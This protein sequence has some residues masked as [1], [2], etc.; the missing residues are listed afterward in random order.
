MRRLLAPLLLALSILVVTPAAAFAVDY[1]VAVGGDDAAGT[2]APD[3]PFASV[4]KAIDVAA[5]GGGNV[6]VGPGTFT[7]NITLK[8]GVSLYGAGATNTTLTVVSGSVITISNIG[9]G[10]TVSGFTITGGSAVYGAGVYCVNSSPVIE[11]NTI[12][13]NSAF[14]ADG[15]ASGGGLH[16]R[17]GAPLIRNN[18]I[19]GNTASG[20]YP[21]GAGIT[22]VSSAATI[23]GNTIVANSVEGDESD[24]MGGSGYGGGIH[25]VGTCYITA[26]TIADNMVTAGYAVGGGVFAIDGSPQIV[27]NTITG[28]LAEG[29][30]AD[31]YDY[32]SAT[33]GG[34]GV[35]RASALIA[36][37]VIADNVARGQ[38]ATAGGLYFNS[39]LDVHTPDIVGNIITGNSAEGVPSAMG[40]GSAS[41]GGVELSDGA[42][43]LIGNV[44]SDNTVSG[45][46]GEAGGVRVSAFWERTT[47]TIANNVITGNTVA[48]SSSGTGAGLVFDSSAAF[49]RN[50]TIADNT[51]QGAYAGAGGVFA[52]DFW[53][54]GRP[55]IKNCILWGNTGAE[56]TGVGAT[57]SCVE[58]G[59]SGEGNTSS[60]PGF[61]DAAGD[62]YS[63]TGDSPCIDMAD[64]SVAPAL[65]IRGVVRPQGVGP[66]TGAYEY[67][68]AT[69]APPAASDDAYVVREDHLLAVHGQGVLANDSVLTDGAPLI[70]SVTTAPSHGSVS[71][72]PRGSFTYMPDADFDGLDS[73]EYTVTDGLGGT[74]VATVTITVTPTSSAPVIDAIEDVVADELVELVVSVTAT[75][76]VAPIQPLVFGLVGD[77]P[78]GASID[79]TTGIFTWTPTEEQGPGE[80]DIHVTVR[81]S[82]SVDAEAFTVTVAEV[83]VAP[84]FDAIGDVHIDECVVSTFTVTAADTDI[85]ANTLTFSLADGAPDGVSI[86]ATTGVLT[87]T[88]TEEQGP[89]AY[90]IPVVVSDGALED[91]AAV[92]VNVAEVNVAPM[93]G[94]IGDQSGDELAPITFTATATDADIPANTLTFALADDAPAGASIDATTGVFTWTP[95]EAHGPAAHEI[96]I[97]ASDGAL[98]DSAT[99][100]V[101]VAEVNTAPALDWIGNQSVTLGEAVAFT[102]SAVDADLPAND[103]AYS[104]QAAPPGATID[105][106]SGEFT[107]TPPTTGVFGMILRVTDGIETDF[108]VV[109]ITVTEPA[110]TIAPL[111]P[112][113]VNAT[114]LSATS[115][116]VSWSASADPSGIRYYTVYLDGVAVTTVA[117]TSAVITGLAPA[118][119]YEFSVAAVDGSPAANASTP[120]AGVSATTPGLP[121]TT[122]PVITIEGVT[123]GA[124]YDAPVTITAS[125]LD[126]VDGTITPLLTLNG[127]PFGSGGTVSAPGAYALVAIAEDAAG[128]SATRSVTFRIVEPAPRPTVIEVAGD[129]RVETAIAASALA[130]PGGSEYVLIATARDFP[131]AL[132]GSALAG[133]LD[134]PILLTEPDALSAATASEI[135][136]LGATRIVVL[137]GEGAVSADAYAQLAGLADAGSIERIAG[138]TRYDTSELIATRVIEELGEGWDGTAFIATGQDFPDALAASPLAAAK[139]WPIYLARPDH[140]EAGALV[141]AMQADGVS[142]VV[143]LGGE[144]VLPEAL[145][146]SLGDAFG[147]SAVERLAG[148][149]RYATAVAVATYGVEEAGLAWD[150]LAIAT[151]EDF[152][153]A[154]AGGALQG[155][156]GSVMILVHPAALHDGIAG[157]LGENKA[158]IAEVRFLGGTGTVPQEVRNAV[159]QA[160][161]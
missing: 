16:S 150:R 156:S 149:N 127:Q 114:P 92:T 100:T 85:P 3:D 108:Q 44:I 32:G 102:A 86:D 119:T 154:L 110:D 58:G 29:A 62:D 111:P 107:W 160:L 135:A 48:V 76:G 13:G 42:P 123:T 145:A 139:S 35:L 27:G 147:E 46:W 69:P 68:S 84:V 36:R 59:A 17:G 71:L 79:A 22:L 152:P 73:F 142:R 67:V 93:L 99:V 8:N 78:P 116:R 25:S 65:D 9:G 74:S 82:A 60:D 87:W 89:A 130:F 97:V 20:A 2:G 77:V 101:N 12:K 106:V 72:D 45:E 61:A 91:T 37:N 98:E 41:G 144:G 19:T 143:M 94:E 21:A 136:R 54:L 33:A 5:V 103:L 18:L 90:E 157:V 57:Y 105:P 28:N 140:A 64:A 7:G 146:Q 95:S 40:G 129:D 126:S 124:M 43:R 112:A 137:G 161:Q 31:A 56:L 75:D 55:D 122:A 148:T 141:T 30:P 39:Q 118:T 4:Q 117:D 11:N 24:G 120:S 151:G 14:R 125:A 34:V 158:S 115:V 53:G 88:P 1:H 6:Y 10:E 104:L 113:D 96:T 121:D 66:D 52:D 80:Y 49:V 131:D 133:L 132:G 155:R 109:V 63:L 15:E 70:A 81:G 83:N 51:V 159:V 26:N 50:N 47:P 153:D 38:G 134:A 138:A 128:N 23:H